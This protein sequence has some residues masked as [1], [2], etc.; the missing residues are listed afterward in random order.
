[1]SYLGIPSGT[2]VDVTALSA[3]LDKQII[4]GLKQLPILMG[5]NEGA[6]TTHG[7]VQLKIFILLIESLRRKVKRLIEFC[8][9][10]AL[11]VAGYQA[12]AH[13]SFEELQTTDR[14]IEA[15]ALESEVR[16]WAALVD[17]G[18]ASDEEA[19]QAILRH[20][21]AGEPRQTVTVEIE[22]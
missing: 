13:V 10:T 20:D 8:H 19:S 9:T 2:M 1:V 6:T 17:R 15:Q 16:T 3:L 7:T 14:L 12:R 22:E 18:W 5:R 21:P 11:Q 4:A